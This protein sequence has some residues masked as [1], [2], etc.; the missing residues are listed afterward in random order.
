MSYNM[1]DFYTKP[2]PLCSP[3]SPPWNTHFISLGHFL[4][5]SMGLYEHVI[6][7]T[8]D[9]H[10]EQCRPD[11]EW[12]TQPD[13][14][15]LIIIVLLRVHLV[16]S[17]VEMM[18]KMM[19]LVLWWYLKY[20]WCKMIFFSL[21]NDTSDGIYRTLTMLRR[22]QWPHMKELYD[23]DS[24]CPIC[25]NSVQCY[26]NMQTFNPCIYT[27]MQWSFAAMWNWMFLLILLLQP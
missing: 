21:W 17:M 7:S 15:I 8:A 19:V 5:E 18:V 27:C 24:T 14:L 1:L 12:L 11:V 22:G 23:Q 9:L 25:R 3:S 4:T 20:L 2:S 6:Y 10:C 26:S 13:K 16:H